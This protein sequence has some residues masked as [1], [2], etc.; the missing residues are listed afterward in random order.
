MDNFDFNVA[1]R[2]DIIDAV[3][4]DITADTYLLD[5]GYAFDAELELTEGTYTIGDII[6][7]KVLKVDE[8]HV[9]VSHQA[10][11]SDE[12]RDELRLEKGKNTVYSGKI[13]RTF[14]NG[15][16]IS[17]DAGMKGFMKLQNYDVSYI[18][19]I[20]EEVGK[21][22]EFTIIADYFGR[23]ADFELDR[24]SLLVAQ[25]EAA[26]Q[27]QYDTL[28][29]GETYTGTIREVK[30]A[31]VWVMYGDI[32]VFI[33]RVET[34]Y[35]RKAV[36]QL[37]K[38]GQ[39]VKFLLMKKENPKRISGSIKQT[40]ESPWQTFTKAYSLNNIIEGTIVRKADFGLFI[41]IGW[42]IDGL[43]HTSELSYNDYID[44]SNFSL[45]EKVK[46]K[47]ISIDEKTHKIGLSIKQTTE[48]PFTLYTEKIALGALVKGKVVKS[49]GAL[50]E[51][52]LAQ[53]VF[54]ILRRGELT[55]G[56][57]KGVAEVYQVGTEVEFKVI[58]IDEQKQRIMLS[59]RQIQEDIERLNFESY[60]T[61][62]L[63]VEANSL[64]KF[65]SN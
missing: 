28:T 14:K 65:F 44:V 54:G 57:T 45:G 31:G 48:N 39:E 61:E 32:T 16:I 27:K 40:Q 12:R 18:Q 38:I 34:S 52:E 6:P 51:V 26:L 7:V 8:E 36:T 59:E 17:F 22:I 58:S 64:S 42:L 4:L 10:A 5:I 63:E 33:P 9:F 53:D 3:V 35:E 56:A 24:K 25:K 41:N 62:K 11:L 37:F 43:V 2:G 23:E 46:V 1:K 50:A 19:N 49:T 60:Q 13:E 29:I 55:Q 20:Q 30:D 15:F 47:L 21:T